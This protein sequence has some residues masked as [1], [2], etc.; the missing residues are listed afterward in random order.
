MNKEWIAS[1]EA[2]VTEIYNFKFLNDERVALDPSASIMVSLLAD[3][4][5]FKLENTIIS[6]KTEKQ[7]A[8]LFKT[9]KLNYVRNNIGIDNVAYR[10]CHD[11][12][13]GNLKQKALKAKDAVA[14]QM[15]AAISLFI[16]QQLRDDGEVNYDRTNEWQILKNLVND[17]KEEVIRDVYYEFAA[18]LNDKGFVKKR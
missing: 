1:F 12:Y 18:E 16:N 2:R 13:E 10:I 4:N 6:E 5:N 14:L 8:L 7:I 11:M 9:E 3:Y 17:S 15:M